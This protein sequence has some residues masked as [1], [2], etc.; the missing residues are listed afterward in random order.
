M[1]C[2]LIPRYCSPVDTHQQDCNPVPPLSQ[3]ILTDGLPGFC[4]ERAE[5]A[6]APDRPVWT[7]LAARFSAEPRTELLRLLGYE[8]AGREGQDG[9]QEG[10]QQQ[11]AE[12][13]AMQV[14]APPGE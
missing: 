6:A 10:Q 14:C 2:L 5:S 3:V 11:E 7:F 12:D 1:I 4:A 13:Q 8:S 9:Q